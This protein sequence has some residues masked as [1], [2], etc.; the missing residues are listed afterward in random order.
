MEIYE[1]G[2]ADGKAEGRI[3]GKAEIIRALHRNGMAAE[4]IAQ[5]TSLPI[6]EV[7]RILEADVSD[8]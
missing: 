1:R 5:N 6:E 2:R 8:A 3:E 7:R 4:A